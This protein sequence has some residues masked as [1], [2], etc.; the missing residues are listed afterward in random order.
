MFGLASG[1]VRSERIAEQNALIKARAASTKASATGTID[2]KSTS[3][4]KNQLKDPVIPAIPIQPF[5]PSDYVD[6]GGECFNITG[7]TDA[8]PETQINTTKS[9]DFICKSKTQFEKTFKEILAK[10]PNMV[11]LFSIYLPYQKEQ[12]R[13]ITDKDKVDLKEIIEARITSLQESV[14]HSNQSIK[15]MQFVKYH[16]NLKNLIKEIDATTA[17]T[18]TTSLSGLEKRIVD[19]FPKKRVYYVLMELAWYLLHPKEIT[20]NSDSWMKLLDTV[21]K[22]NLGA[23]VKK[24][25]ETNPHD[26]RIDVDRV[27]EA[28]KLH[29]GIS[30]PDASAELKKRLESILQLFV[31]RKYLQSPLRR[32][33]NGPVVDKNIIDQLDR[34][35]PGSYTAPIAGG[36]NNT[37]AMNVTP[38]NTTSATNNKNVNSFK[39]SSESVANMMKPFYDFFKEKYDPI[40]SV[41]SRGS[42]KDLPDGLSLV[43]LSKLLFICQ[44]ITSQSPIQ[45]GMYRITNIDPVMMEFLRTQLGA[46]QAYVDDASRTDEERKSF[47]DEAGLVPV[48]S[49]K[50]LL[51]KFG[52][53]GHYTDPETI[54]TV[55]I[56]MTGMNIDPYATKDD[57]KIDI[58]DDFQK[59]Q[60]YQAAT[61]FFTDQSIYLVCNEAKATH[62]SMNVFEVNYLDVNVSKNEWKVDNMEE[63]YFNKFKEPPLFLEDVMD[64]KS[65]IVYNHGMLAL[66]MFIAS[67]ELLPK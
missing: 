6:I 36:G 59:E 43:S 55:R 39:I 21:E 35:L 62:T 11:R 33:D 53:S 52:K 24:I 14:K 16:N 4:N 15:N 9:Y 63:N 31:A 47:T 7:T 58:K 50:S 29:K 65:N 32:N 8:P 46:V 1:V 48:V 44:K 41:L 67:E 20:T 28:D 18:S 25:H 61:T 56:M 37:N 54:P 51:N 10:F 42:S 3:S 23:F 49:I 30:P 66:S 34:K 5:P 57:M 13:G 45:H 38:I 19:K 27:G 17:T 26:M 2:P 40:A 12:L 22:L 60:I 64:V